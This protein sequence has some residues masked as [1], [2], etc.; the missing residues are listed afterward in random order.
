MNF[1]FQKRKDNLQKLKSEHFDLLIIGGGITGA[2]IARDAASRGMKVALIEAQDFAIGTSSRSSKLI[3]GG[4]RYLENFEFHLVFEALAERA[5]LF[6]IAPHL[7]H[8]LRFLIPI[9]KHSRVGRF[10]MTLGMWLYDLLALF[11]TP[12]MHESLDSEEVKK[13]LPSLDARGLTGAVEY[14]DAY[15]DDDRLVIE[16]LRDAHRSGA[17]IVNYVKALSSEKASEKEISAVHVM[18][19]ISGEEFK[20]KASQVVSGVG[21]WTDLLGQKLNKDWTPRLRPTKG[22]H[23]V[24]SKKRIPVD[25]AVVMAVEKRIIFV[26]PRHEM[27]IVGTTD[28]D[29]KHDPSNVTTDVEDVD[30]LIAAL[31]QYFPRLD[32]TREDIISSYSGV[33]PLVDDGSETESKTSREHSIFEFGPNLTIVAGGKYT[34]YRKISEEAVDFILNKMPFE[35]RMTFG[36]SNTRRVLNPRITGE[37][38][39]RALDKVPVYAKKFLIDQK[40]VQKIIF[41]H[42]EEGETLLKKIRQDYVT[43]SANDALWMA[44]AFFAIENTMCLNLVDFYWRRSP[45]FLASKNHGSQY[46][47]SI[48]R[49]FSQYY[50]WSDEETRLQKQTLLQQMQ[51]EL[52]WKAEA[53]N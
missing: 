24:F 45:L 38:Y 21:P 33:R 14:S 37:L 31:Q 34:T 11:E 25:K 40:L 23:L 20:I 41:R 49:V 30:Y 12:Q 17:A 7:V 9:Y 46:I 27:V 5:L 39:S 28:T 1:N 22:V 26:I 13:R 15:T 50:N 32:L 42:G 19:E 10:K 35:K 2:G 47:S 18:D 44:E 53:F 16:T 52:A 43:Y 36:P 51:K 48:A 6:K 4:V 8:P 29:F 3:H